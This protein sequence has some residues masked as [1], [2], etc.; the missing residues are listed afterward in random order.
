MACTKRIDSS[1]FSSN[2]LTFLFAERMKME[3]RVENSTVKTNQGNG[4]EI[5]INGH[6]QPNQ[7]EQPS[8]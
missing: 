7:T 2:F 3:V 4:R 8:K 1:L 6:E 5:S